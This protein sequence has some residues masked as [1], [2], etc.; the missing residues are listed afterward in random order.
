[1]IRNISD[2]GHTVMKSSMSHYRDHMEAPLTITAKR[3]GKDIMS[4]IDTLR[5]RRMIEAIPTA[6]I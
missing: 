6:A 1:M 2:M 4:Y 5:A 3:M